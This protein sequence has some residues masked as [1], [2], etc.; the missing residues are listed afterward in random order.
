M[1]ASRL[2]VV[3]AL[4]AA[5]DPASA[6]TLPE[7]PALPGAAMLPSFAE[8]EAMGAII[9]RVLVN[10]QDIFDLDDPRENKSLYR[11]ANRLHAQTRPETIRRQL[12]FLPGE[13]VSARIIDETER[14]LRG[15]R[16]LQDVSIRPVDYRDG[17]VDIEVKRRDTWT[18]DPGISVARSGGSNSQRTYLNEHNLL[19]SGV[20]LGVSHS[21]NV[22]RA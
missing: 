8:L 21:A 7:L 6:Q 3:I 20:S 5:L 18:L 4:L 1:I 9:G 11:L 16:Y 2:L 13:R 14:L 19:G 22:E 12:L 17:V 15:N 10:S